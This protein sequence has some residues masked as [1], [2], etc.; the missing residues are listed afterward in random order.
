VAGPGTGTGVEVAT[1]TLAC[2]GIHPRGFNPR[3]TFCGDSRNPKAPLTKCIAGGISPMVS[4]DSGTPSIV[5]TFNPSCCMATFWAAVP[6]APSPAPIADSTASLLNGLPT[7]LYPAP[8]NAAAV[9]AD[10]PPPIAAAFLASGTACSADIPC[11][12]ARIPALRKLSHAPVA[13]MAP[14]PPT[15]APTGPPTT[16]PT[17]AAP[18]NSP[19]D[20]PSPPINLP[21]FPRAVGSGV[22]VDLMNSS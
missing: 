10:T 13:P 15:T 6:P 11:C 22:L 4:A 3:G 17:P 9:T 1:G 12:I 20:P 7:T 5:G 2:S 14:A 16:P 19:M 21:A 8:G 18:M